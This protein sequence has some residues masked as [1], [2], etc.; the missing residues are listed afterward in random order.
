MERQAE[1]EDK[2][3]LLQTT[4]AKLNVKLVSSGADVAFCRTTVTAMS[5]T[6]HRRDDMRKKTKAAAW[7]GDGKKNN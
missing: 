4:A 5:A 2:E 7:T 1:T 6:I 3:E